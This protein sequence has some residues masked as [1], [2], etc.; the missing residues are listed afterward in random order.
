M[1]YDFEET[2]FLTEIPAP[3]AQSSETLAETS[4]EFNNNFGL[5]GSG[6]TPKRP[7]QS[8]FSADNNSIAKLI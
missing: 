3:G 2:S 8:R 1:P 5:V 4:F 6:L 7:F